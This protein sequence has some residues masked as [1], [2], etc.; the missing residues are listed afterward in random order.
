MTAIKEYSDFLAGNPI[1]SSTRFRALDETAL[2]GDSCCHEFPTL[3]C[4]LKHGER[5]SYAVYLIEEL[6]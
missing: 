6:V 5:L 3:L 4:N 1:R 2:Y